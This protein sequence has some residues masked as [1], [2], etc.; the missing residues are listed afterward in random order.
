MGEFMTN[1]IK[2]SFLPSPE[3]KRSNRMEIYGQA[4]YYIKTTVLLIMETVSISICA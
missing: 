4:L 1:L 3:K 2:E